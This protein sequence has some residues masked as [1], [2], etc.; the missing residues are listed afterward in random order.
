M[1][2]CKGWHAVLN[3]ID[4]RRWCTVQVMHPFSGTK[5]IKLLVSSKAVPKV[6]ISGGDSSPIDAHRSINMEFANRTKSTLRI[7]RRQRNCLSMRTPSCFHRIQLHRYNGACNSNPRP[8][9]SSVQSVSPLE[10]NR[11]NGMWTF[12]ECG[13]WNVEC[14]CVRTPCFV[15]P[16]KAS[17][18]HAC[19]HLVDD[20]HHTFLL[21][22]ILQV[23]EEPSRGVAVTPLC[24][25]L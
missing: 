24:L 25:D 7:K 17:A 1:R 20:Q 21:A 8:C 11:W 19:L 12:A 15:R 13:M 2:V 3:I 23:L 9:S 18:H 4:V 14:A 16:P 22:H 6:T 10:S 5:R